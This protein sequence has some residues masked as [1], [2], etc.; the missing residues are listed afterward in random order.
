MDSTRTCTLSAISGKHHHALGIYVSRKTATQSI[1]IRAP[2]LESRN[3]AALGEHHSTTA[4]AAQRKAAPDLIS[5][6]SL[7][8]RTGL[9]GNIFST[10]QEICG[11][12]PPIAP[13]HLIVFCSSGLP[14]PGA[15]HGSADPLSPDHESRA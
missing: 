13:K 6:T 11:Q 15:N 4:K 2:A 7:Q 8:D 3:R 5:L 14:L 10:D 1:R 9:A 12:S